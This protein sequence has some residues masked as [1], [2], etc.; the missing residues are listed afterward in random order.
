M[1]AA[2]LTHME[3]GVAVIAIASAVKSAYN[4]WLRGM[5]DNIQMIP[6]IRE[7]QEGMQETQDRLVDATIALSIAESA[8]DKEVD[9][10]EVERALKQNGS[11]RDYLRETDGVRSPYSDYEDEEVDE[12][13]ARWRQQY[14]GD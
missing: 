9:P 10:S 2:L 7:S 12:E 11:A 5:I 13:E 14:D 3:I 8:E 6:D 4:G 1:A